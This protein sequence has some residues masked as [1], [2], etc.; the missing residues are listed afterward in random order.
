MT[1]AIIGAG[2][3]GLT[4]AYHL[5]GNVILFEKSRGLGGRVATRWYDRPGGRVYIDHGAQ[6]I[7]TEAPTLQQM[8][9]HDLPTPDLS[10]I[11]RP[12][13][14]FDGDQAIREGDAALNAQP[15][16]SYRRGLAS[17]GHY[18][19]GQAG[20]TVHTR[21]RIAQI[22]LQAD[23]QFCLTDTDGQNV[24]EF[25]QVIIAIPAPQAADLINHSQ[26][27]EKL[28]L[29]S[30]LRRAVYRRCLSVVLGYE[31]TLP[32]RPYYA[33]LSQNRDHAIG[34]VGFEHDKPDHLSEGQSALVVQ[35]SA[36][37]SLAHWE[38][39][40]P[41]LTADVAERV[42]RLLGEDMTDVTWSDVQRW[43]YSQPE[44][45][46]HMDELNGKVANLWFAGDY[47][48]GGRVSLAAETGREVA[49]AIRA[50]E[51]PNQG[52]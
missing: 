12:V 16:W 39:D 10:D 32:P 23:G 46:L 45:L 28:A 3:A 22:D 15:R 40:G 14:L 1:I 17:L 9:L 25:T 43:R 35:M 5:R 24:G 52:N 44:S 11:A 18:I 6:Y 47:L 27:P 31:R 7:K 20:L 29:E 26:T 49:E 50:T 41:T 48:R 42:S 36:A 4:A 2:V 38:T 13:W 8:I 19:V 30:T 51:D 37:F 34:W 33:L 21:T